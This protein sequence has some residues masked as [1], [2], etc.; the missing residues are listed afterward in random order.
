M[1]YKGR[2]E[3]DNGEPC[4]ETYK[5]PWVGVGKLELNSGKAWGALE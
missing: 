4:L 1:E 2:G 5:R 3:G